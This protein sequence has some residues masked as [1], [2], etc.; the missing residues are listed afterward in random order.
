MPY[1]L[2]IISRYTDIMFF[3]VD[4]DEESADSGSEVEEDDEAEADDDVPVFRKQKTSVGG[5]VRR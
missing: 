3:P 4:D 1:T 2:E 5:S